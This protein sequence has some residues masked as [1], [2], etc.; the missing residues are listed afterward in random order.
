MAFGPLT[1]LELGSQVASFLVVV[2]WALSYP[3]V[4][5][6]VGGALTSRLF[7]TIGSH[8][9]LPGIRNRFRWDTSS[10]GTLFT[11]GRWIFFGSIFELLSAQSD[12]MLLGRYL[13]IG[14]LGVYSIAITLTA[15]V[16]ALTMKI[17][18][19]V[20]FPAYGRVAREDVQR[21]GQV[22][23]RARLGIDIF[24]VFPISMLIV[25]GTWLVD[26]MYDPRYHEAG[27]MLQILCIRPLMSATLANSEACLIA[28]GQP[29]YAFIQ[30]ACRAIWI[31]VGVPVAWHLVGVVGVVW[32]VA[33]AELPVLAVL[34]IGLAR[35][36]MLSVRS[37]IRTV[38]FVAFGI[39]AGL[40][41]QHMLIQ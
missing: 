40:L 38:M 14:Q 33:L 1:L 28:L 20:L 25:L 8:R 36:K 39:A 30:N 35:F 13:G 10:I 27:W 16:Q 41:L 2:A 23:D 5:A 18:S 34:W 3:T 17:N 22:T 6:L 29:K 21:L 11:F 7:V 26:L 4:W 12:R 9:L 24:I 37:E 19:G 31:M 15:A 32:A